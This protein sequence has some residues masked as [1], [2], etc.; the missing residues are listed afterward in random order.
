MKEKKYNMALH[1]VIFCKVCS[2]EI[3]IY[4]QI[5]NISIRF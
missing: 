1:T 2:E 4:E 3:V 5:N